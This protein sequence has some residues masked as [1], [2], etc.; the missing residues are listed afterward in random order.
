MSP[1]G[2]SRPGTLPD[3]RNHHLDPDT[4]PPLGVTLRQQPGDSATSGA[5]VAVYAGHAD[6]IELCIFRE[7]Q[8]EQRILLPHRRHGVHFGY[9]PS[10]AAGTRYGFRA[11]GPW[12]PQR[13]LRHNPNKLLIDPYARGHCGTLNYD[14]AIYAHQHRPGH[15]VELELPDNRD[16]QAHIPKS[17]VLSGD[18]SWDGETRPKIPGSESVIYELHVRGFTQKLP[19]VPVELRG[20]YAGLAQPA[21]LDYLVNLG[22]TTVELLPI[23]AFISEPRLDALGLTNYWGYNTLG[24]FAPHPGYA[25]VKDAARNPEAVLH[26]VK[27]MVRAVHNAGLEIVLDVVYNHTCEQG[28]EGPTLSW[29]GLDNRAYY[30]LDDNGRDMD[31]TGCGNTL[32]FR[33]PQVI[34]MALDSLRYWVTEV[35]IDGFRFDLASALARGRDG[36]YHPDHPFLVALRTDPVLSRVKLIAEPWDVGDYGWRTGQFPPPMAEWNDRFR[37][38][39]RS[40]WLA[41][42]GRELRGETGHGVQ[43]LATRISGSQDLFGRLD[44]GPT[45]SINYL[46][47]HDGFT[48][49]DAVSYDQKHNLANKEDNRD[50]HGDNRSWNHGW[51]GPQATAEIHEDR[52][53]SLRNLLGTLLCATGVPMLAAGDECGRTQEGNNNAYCQDNDLSWFDWDFQP[54]HRDLLETTKFLLK[55]RRDFPV[56]RQREFFGH[57][58]AHLSGTKDLEWFHLTGEPMTEGDWQDHRIRSLQVFLHAGGLNPTGIPKAKNQIPHT[59]L[60][61]I[62]HGGAKPTEIS[63]PGAPWASEY[64]KLWDSCWPRP[65]EPGHPIEPGALLVPP[66]TM[67]IW[68]VRGQ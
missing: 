28:R 65:E 1:H 19:G 50:G 55:L 60:L 9:V 47:A 29:R 49:A 6:A 36:G 15:T 24:F 42:A 54:A 43:D 16:S 31:V 30:R 17:V 18:F 38:T 13:G 25:S 14:S 57:R 34:K 58:P 53:R 62:L 63:L 7:D 59:G 21:S 68:A 11:F 51:E 37:D 20:T 23:Q 44:R 12:D 41:D 66:R 32:D 40:F 27:N 4:P 10:V 48:L 22:V 67:Q 35:H 46:A 8:Q 5:D 33:H 52:H 56:L 45:A 39:I 26:E 61:V 2:S 3:V 64:R